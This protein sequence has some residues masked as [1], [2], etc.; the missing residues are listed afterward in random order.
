MSGGDD[1]DDSSMMSSSLLTAEDDADEA[2]ENTPKFHP[3]E[4]VFVPE[5][6]G[7]LYEAVIK[8]TALSNGS[9]KYLVHYLGWNSRWDNWIKQEDVDGDGK[10]HSPKIFKDTPETRRAMAQQKEEQQKEAKRKREAEEK[11][12][13]NKKHH[14]GDSSSSSSAVSNWAMDC[15]ELPFTL[16]TI[17]VED[18]E[19]VMRLGLEAPHTQY[20]CDVRRWTPT[21]DVHHLP[22]TVTIHHVLQHYIKIS[23]SS[24]AANASDSSS[25][26]SSAKA[27]VKELSDIFEEALPVCL[28]YH[29]E[30]AQFQAVKADPALQTKK[31]VEIYGNDFLLRLCTRLPVLLMEEAAA[32]TASRQQQRKKEFSMHM[33]QLIQLLQKNRSACFKTKY[34]PPREEELNQWEIALR[35]GAAKQQKRQQQLT[36]QK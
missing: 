18:R 20:D 23:S 16:Q 19:R 24:S 12:N 34:R 28:L 9:W 27:F 31:L 2:E 1:D 6:D 13:P 25:S 30:R 11:A 22:A 5:S 29:T 15:C 10:D 7:L 32:A 26:S 21:R 8:K 33:T 4:K 36:A 17:L 3:D 14:G 35:T